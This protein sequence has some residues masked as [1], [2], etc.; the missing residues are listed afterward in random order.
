MRKKNKKNAKNLKKQ[1][2]QKNHLLL[3]FLFF[4][5]FFSTVF[6]AVKASNNK[7][8]NL[9]NFAWIGNNL[10]YKQLEIKEMGDPVIGMLSVSGDKYQVSMNGDENTKT[11][12]GYAWIGI[13]KDND[14][15]KNFSDNQNDF[16]SLG[17][18]AFNQGIP[19]GNCFGVGDCH[20]A[21]WNR[22]AGF[23]DLTEGYLSGWAKLVIGKDGSGVNYP[24]SWVHFKSPENT[25]YK[26]EGTNNYFVCSDSNGKMN[27]FAW[28]S[29]IS[30]HYTED[31]PGLGWINFSEIVLS[32][33]DCDPSNDETC[34][35]KDGVCNLK[36]PEKVDPDCGVVPAS[37]SYCA[38]LLGNEATSKTICGENAT[39]N[40]SVFSS[41]LLI[42]PDDRFEWQ[43]KEGDTP[44]FDQ[45]N[46]SCSYSSTGIFRPSLKIFD[47]NGNERITCSSG[48][49]SVTE[50][51]SCKIIL[52]KY[53]SSDEYVSDLK[54]FV[55]DQV[56]AMVERNCLKEGTVNWKTDGNGT[57]TNDYGNKAIFSFAQGSVGTIEASI[58]TTTCEGANVTAK[59]RVK[60]GQ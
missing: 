38:V 28:S 57:K 53:G 15:Y 4:F 27:G 1:K 8:F 46:I 42:S 20:P 31:N 39:V 60:W 19:E 11:L 52:R 23:T 10:Q 2:S 51:N 13:G 14:K 43:C 58:D 5:L 21:R 3:F 32:P 18:I 35:G 26:C 49:V 59:D 7:I 22:K 44:V 41:G 50:N 54:V 33:A 40:L 37:N 9:T 36:C 29:E 55:G 30:S 48:T 45:K 24:E 16:P 25:D 12:S 6:F 17:W 56:E 47:K 34:C